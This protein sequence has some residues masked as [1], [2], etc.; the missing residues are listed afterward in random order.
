MPIDEAV[1]K[2]IRENDPTLEELKFRDL[3][4]ED[5][6]CL[7]QAL[8]KDSCVKKI[9]IGPH[10]LTEDSYPLLLQLV[11]SKPSIVRLGFELI[12]PT[13]SV[14]AAAASMYNGA[15]ARVLEKNKNRLQADPTNE[16]K[17][18]PTL[19]LAFTETRKSASET[20]EQSSHGKGSRPITGL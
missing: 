19:V 4:D 16:K 1:L 18:Q 17:S 5:V 6:R 3:R 20:V 10:Q 11:E 2:A 13:S 12:M 8:P 14:T 7:I 15:I 9:Y